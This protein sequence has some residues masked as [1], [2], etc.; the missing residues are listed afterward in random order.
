MERIVFTCNKCKNDFLGEK[1]Q[2]C[3]FCH[4]SDVS[5]KSVIDKEQTPSDDKMQRKNKS[6][7][8]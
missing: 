8:K 4:S 1:K 2:N 6:V 3:I 5:V 7:T